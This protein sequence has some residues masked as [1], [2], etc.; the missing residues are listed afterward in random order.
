VSA[1]YG[2]Y[3]AVAVLYIGCAVVVQMMHAALTSKERH[4]SQAI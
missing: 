1:Y 2:S 3:V 4:D